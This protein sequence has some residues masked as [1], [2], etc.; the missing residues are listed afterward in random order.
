[1]LLCAAFFWSK[2]TQAGEFPQPKAGHRLQGLPRFEAQHAWLIYNTT[3]LHMLHIVVRRFTPKSELR[4]MC[5]K[6]QI[7]SNQTPICS[8]YALSAFLFFYCTHLVVMW[9]WLQFRILMSISILP[10]LEKLVDHCWTIYLLQQPFYNSTVQKYV[11]MISF[12]HTDCKKTCPLNLEYFVDVICECSTIDSK[13]V[14]RNANCVE[15]GWSWQELKFHSSLV[16]RFFQVTLVCSL[17]SVNNPW[18]CCCCC[19]LNIE[20]VQSSRSL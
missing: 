14:A 6:N 10:L 12:T 2:K 19:C 1:V 5:C 11:T 4:L 8:Q 15:T 9:D 18:S 13:S 3:L 16:F 7:K 17:S 20:I